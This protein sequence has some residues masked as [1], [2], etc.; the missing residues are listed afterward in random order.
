MNIPS[1]PQRSST[2]LKELED[3]AAAAGDDRIARLI[4]AVDR[5]LSGLQSFASDSQRTITPEDLP[6]PSFMVNAPTTIK[7]ED[8]MDVDAATAP[9]SPRRKHHASDSG[10]G[11][12]VSDD[13]DMK[14]GMALLVFVLQHNDSHLTLPDLNKHRFAAS[15]SIAQSGINGTSSLAADL[16][17]A[18]QHVLGEYACRQIQKHIIIPII[19][20]EK[21]KNFHPLVSGLPYRIARK[22]ITCLRDLEK[23]LLWLAPVCTY[24]SRD[25]S[26]EQGLISG[27]K[28]WSVSKAAFLQFCETSI[29]CIHATVD[30]LN[31]RDQRRPTDRPYTN[32]YF[33]DLVEQVR[34]YAAHLA[35]TR[36]RMPANERVSL[37]GGLGR[38]GRPAELV[39]TRDGKTISLRTGQELSPEEMKQG[40]K[41]S[42]A[43]IDEDLERSMAR[44]RKSAPAVKEVQR[45]SE[46]AKI[47]KRPCDLTYALAQHGF[48]S[49]LTSHRK[50]EKTHSRPWKCSEVNCKYHGYG[51]PTEKERDRHMN[52]KHSAAPSMYRCKFSPC[53]YESK[54]ESNCKQHM[55]KA[56]GWT[57]VRSKNNGKAIPKAKTSGNAPPTPLDSTPG[58]HI[59]SAPTPDFHDN[60]SNFGT[61]A[62]SHYPTESVNG[63]VITSNASDTYQND[64]MAFDNTFGPVGDFNWD[65]ADGFNF[66]N[67]SHRESWDSAMND[68]NVMPSTFGALPNEDE[69]IF[70]S[71]FDWS[72]MGDLT[73][74][75]MQLASPA[76]SVDHLPIDVFNKPEPHSLQAPSLSPVGR[77]D[78]MLYSPY[79]YSSSE[80]HDEGY[81]GDFVQD[82]KPGAD[83]SLFDSATT[84][85]IN[86]GSNDAMFHDLSAFAASASWNEKADLNDFM[87][88]EQ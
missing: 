69:S 43:E 11:S 27:V 4:G 3:C 57:Y 51:W 67:D 24:P 64:A 65:A 31:E 36:S 14:Q 37:V 12:T 77:A 29:Q 28:K 40:L 38:S 30:H 86:T 81:G 75:N 25:W 46:C 18:Q 45:C 88:M 52:D 42:S 48:V 70:G 74:L 8:L 83:F 76:T 59:F 9:V 35:A 58:S 80:A 5:T 87:R 66:T 73:S 82:L 32:G 13:S 17:G 33:L 68:P 16:A 26:L 22:E 41:R 50:H 62:S 71:N 34:Q 60:G 15:E 7:D 39:R 53:P 54:R 56:H 21:L 49:R 23:V 84:S 55:E 47:F 79:S 72:N 2:T 63:S 1:L 20:E 44:R 19:R 61:P 10:I 78:A 6:V 85:G